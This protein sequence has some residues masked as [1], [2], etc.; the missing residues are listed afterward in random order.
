M[1]EDQQNII[2]GRRLLENVAATAAPTSLME[3]GTA[4]NSNL[5]KIDDVSSLIHE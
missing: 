4:G 5:G 1:N 3:S 2:C